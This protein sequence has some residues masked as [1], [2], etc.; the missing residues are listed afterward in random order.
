MS[1]SLLLHGVHQRVFQK[2][3]SRA[4]LTDCWIFLD[5]DLGQIVES[6]HTALE[7]PEFFSSSKV[8]TSRSENQTSVHCEQQGTLLQEAV[9]GKSQSSKQ[10]QMPIDAVV[11]KR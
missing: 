3:A 4:G 2:T 7:S 6:P 9:Q 10:G 1:D 8:L 5:I 11:N